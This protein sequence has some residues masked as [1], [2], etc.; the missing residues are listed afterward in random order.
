MPKFGHDRRKPFM[1]RPDVE[2]G[3][4]AG[5][6][7]RQLKPNTNMSLTLQPR[8]G[9]RCRRQRRNDRPLPV[10]RG[11]QQGHDQGRQ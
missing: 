8:A 3:Y 2:S 10:A 7:R 4:I 9:S 11:C 1:R 5:A 6:V